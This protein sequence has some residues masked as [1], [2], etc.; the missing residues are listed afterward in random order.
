MVLERIRNM[1]GNP[2]Q[3]NKFKPGQSGNPN[4]RPK[5]LNDQDMLIMLQKV[6]EL[7]SVAQ[8]KN[9]TIGFPAQE[10]INRLK[11]LLNN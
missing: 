3:T 1:Y 4:G 8:S 11:N 10:K 6:I 5:K 2:P 7:Y 9:K